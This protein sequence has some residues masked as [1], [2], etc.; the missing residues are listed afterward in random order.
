MCLK[1]RVTRRANER[2]REQASD[3]SQTLC[4]TQDVRRG[5]GSDIT[6][7]QVVGADSVICAGA[8]TTVTKAML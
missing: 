8:A 1:L 3:T 4:V 7:T 2:R 6:F 5:P